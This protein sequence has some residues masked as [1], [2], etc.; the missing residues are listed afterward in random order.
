MTDQQALAKPHPIQL[1]SVNVKE[2]YIKP[3]VSPDISVGVAEGNVCSISVGHSEYNTENHTIVTFIKLEIGEEGKESN[4]PF[5]LKIELVATFEVDETRFAVEHLTDFARWNAPF[6]MMPYL[7]EHA[8]SLSSKCGFKP[9]IL[10][11]TEVPTNK[12]V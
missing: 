4:T 7:R 5:N 2:L 1:I 12:P 11:L 6:I 3:N 10:P 9:I 8:F